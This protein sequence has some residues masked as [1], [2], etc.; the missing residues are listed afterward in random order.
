VGRRRMSIYVTC[1]SC[2]REDYFWK[3]ARVE[4]GETLCPACYQDLVSKVGV[5]TT[6]KEYHTYL[7]SDAEHRNIM[8]EYINKLK[9]YGTYFKDK[10]FINKVIVMEEEMCQRI[11]HM[12]RSNICGTPEELLIVEWI[13]MELLELFPDVTTEKLITMPSNLFHTEHRRY[14]NIEYY[15]IL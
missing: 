11:Y 12:S 1:G 14:Y 13:Q 2:D 9:K 15:I 6:L 5:F 7:K 8:N 3:S 4:S 10:E